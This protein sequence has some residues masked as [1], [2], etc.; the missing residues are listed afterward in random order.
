MDALTTAQSLGISL[1]S[2]AYLFAALVFGFAGFAAYRFGKRLERPTTKWLG[3]A[4]MLYPYVVTQTWLVWLVGSALCMGI[5][6][7]NR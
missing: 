6:F 3:V 2:P 5:W 1:P 4:L 7:D